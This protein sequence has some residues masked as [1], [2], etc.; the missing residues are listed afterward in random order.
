MGRLENEDQNRT[1]QKMIWITLIYTGMIFANSATPAVYSSEES[2]WVTERMNA[3][4]QQIGVSFFSFQEGFVRK[5]AH[6]TEYSGLGVLLTLSLLSYPYFQGKKRF[7]LIPIGFVIAC[8]D[9]SIQYFTPGRDCNFM[10][11]CLDTCGVAF[12]V[13]LCWL[14]GKVKEQ[15]VRKRKTIS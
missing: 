6:F 5:L 11:V 4:L 3:F 13:C 15:I 7:L 10:D 2:N 1:K 9:E 14:L 8:I 12:G